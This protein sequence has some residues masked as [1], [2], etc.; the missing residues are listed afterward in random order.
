MLFQ[1]SPK[2]AL[3]GTTDAARQVEH[4]PS[5]L[6]FVLDGEKLHNVVGLIEHL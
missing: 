6:L 4:R 2:N 1:A 3:Q 5:V